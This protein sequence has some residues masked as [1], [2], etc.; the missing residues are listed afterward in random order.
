[1][2]A[3]SGPEVQQAAGRGRYPDILPPLQLRSADGVGPLRALCPDCAAPHAG[4]AARRPRHAAA[5]APALP[6]RPRARGVPAPE[7]PGGAQPRAGA[8]LGGGQPR[9]HHPGVVR[10]RGGWRDLRPPR[11]GPGR[12]LRRHRHK[13]RGTGPGAHGCAQPRQQQRG[14]VHNTLHARINHLCAAVPE[15]DLRAAAEGM[16][17]EG[18]PLR[19]VRGYVGLHGDARLHQRR[20]LD[21]IAPGGST[22]DL[23][24][25]RLGIQDD[26]W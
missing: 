8:G 25:L 16:A 12:R 4:L 3:E 22:G 13:Y 14:A 2:A 15:P 6:D 20:R 1:M 9:A 24:M 19:A 26:P 5:A 23:P 18:D 11:R 17:A 7:V 21:D 10:R